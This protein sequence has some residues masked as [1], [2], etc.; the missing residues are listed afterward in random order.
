VTAAA[1]SLAPGPRGYR[2]DPVARFI[3]TIEG[4]GFTDLEEIELPLIPEVGDAIETKFGTCI[5][6][7]AESLSDSGQ[8]A[9]KI[10]C[11]YS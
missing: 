6:T 11:R 7:R 2:A 5:V 10:V 1:R 3:I 9:G 4:P 8:Y